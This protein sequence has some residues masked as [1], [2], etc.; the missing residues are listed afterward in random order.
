MH[1]SSMILSMRS[2]G[3]FIEV[4]CYNQRSLTQEP[5]IR[6]ILAP[7]NF[8]NTRWVGLVI[9]L[10]ANNKVLQIKYVDP[11]RRPVFEDIIPDEIRESL[12]GAY[13]S[14]IHIKNLA[15]LSKADG[16]T[17]GALTV[18][19]LIRAAQGRYDAEIIQEEQ[20]RLIRKRHIDILERF[21]P[22]MKFGFKQANGI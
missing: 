7:V 6:T 16:M 15:L 13:G 17:S 22:D 8:N 9:S 1:I 11:L 14:D 2:V 20:T 4:L 12:R 21:M 5:V 18:E 3:S 19:N 10:D